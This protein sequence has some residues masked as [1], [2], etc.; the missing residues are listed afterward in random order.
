MASVSK[1]LK[2]DR[3]MTFITIRLCDSFKRTPQNLIC[4]F[5]RAVESVRVFYRLQQ[6]SL[7]N[8][9]FDA[10]KAVGLQ[11]INITCCPGG[12]ENSTDGNIFIEYKYPT[13]VWKEDTFIKYKDSVKLRLQNFNINNIIVDQVMEQST[14]SQPL[15]TEIDYKI[16]E[17]DFKF[18]NYLCQYQHSKSPIPAYPEDIKTLLIELKERRIQIAL[19]S[20]NAVGKSFILN[21]LLLLSAETNSKSGEQGRITIPKEIIGNPT[22]KRVKEDQLENLPEVIKDFLVEVDDD[23]QDFKNLVQPICHE[24]HFTDQEVIN[25]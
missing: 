25:H 7:K 23:E 12:T 5:I 19:L 24:L 14:L 22:V 17:L 1:K 21:L 10:G 18:Q 9:L 6:Q 8:I 13:E 3:S 16:H 11:F 4:P 15:I 20:H 2:Y